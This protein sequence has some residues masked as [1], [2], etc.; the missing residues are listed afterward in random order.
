[1]QDTQTQML[2]GRYLEHRYPSRVPRSYPIVVWGTL[3]RALLSRSSKGSGKTHSGTYRNYSPIDNQL[4]KSLCLQVPYTL[5]LNLIQ[6]LYT[7]FEFPYT[8]PY[9]P[10]PRIP[11]VWIS[12]DTCRLTLRAAYLYKA[13]HLLIT[14]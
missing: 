9:K 4:T 5:A 13:A 6:Y 7:P 8:P 2:G 3:L 14:R 11:K 1:M 12:C 10:Y